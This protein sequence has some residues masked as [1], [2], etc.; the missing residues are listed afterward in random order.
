MLENVVRL[1]RTRFLRYLTLLWIII[2]FFAEM[3]ID[4]VKKVNMVLPEKTRAIV[5]SI[6][7]KL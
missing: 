2:V 7:L 1:F 6:S 3:I 4:T 5:K